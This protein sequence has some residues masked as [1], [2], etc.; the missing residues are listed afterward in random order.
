MQR[1][2]SP[3]RTS[4]GLLIEHWEGPVG[5]EDALARQEAAVA[6]VLAGGRER[7]FLLEH[8]PVLTVGT[9]G[10]A[11]DVLDGGDIPVIPT[12][13][14]G[15]VTWHGPGQRVG[16]VICDLNRRE[17]D[18]RAHVKLLQDII[19]KTL[20]PFGIDA[21]TNDDIGVWVTTPR[22][23]EKIA[24][25]GVRVRRW[26]TY[27][28]FALNVCPDLAVYKRFIPCG[29]ADRGVTSMAALGFTGSMAEVDAVLERELRAALEA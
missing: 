29:I 8:S 7:V 18:I 3:A 21:H 28:G 19:I 22:G 4:A 1:E 12:G 11:A 24:A 5:Y 25:I 23:E 20:I 15:K 2:L 6:D 27:H 9:S 17:R 10:D 26:V 16:Y 13:R 14:G